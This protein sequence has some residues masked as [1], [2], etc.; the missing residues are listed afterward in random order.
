MIRA[1]RLDDL[2][3]LREIERAAGASFRAL[4]MAAVADDEPPSVTELA[5]FVDGDRAWVCADETDRP[6]GYL[7]ASVIEGCGHIEQV[8]VRPDHARLGLGRSLL[9]AAD[10][11]AQQQGLTALTLTTYSEVPWNAPY[12]RRLGFEVLAEDEMTDGLLRIR[13]REAAR[14]LAAWPRVTMRRPVNKAGSSAT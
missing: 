9:A 8:S 4:G 14:G 5:S 12:Y 10:T 1:A 11:W 13:H 6:M 7:L 3:M 2:A